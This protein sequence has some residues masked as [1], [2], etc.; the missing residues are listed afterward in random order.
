MFILNVIVSI[1]HKV[2]N[3]L[4]VRE[5]K[6]HCILFNL[7]FSTFYNTIEHF[8]NL[9]NDI[10]NNDSPK[11]RGFR[12]IIHEIFIAIFRIPAALGYML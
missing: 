1:H 8:D 7:Y 10:S 3:F 2:S 4:T 12:A 5:F 9:G 6:H 11:A